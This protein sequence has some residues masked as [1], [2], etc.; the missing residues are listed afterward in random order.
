[1]IDG[2]KNRQL[3]TKIDKDDCEDQLNEEDREELGGDGLS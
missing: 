1:M 3:G 2:G